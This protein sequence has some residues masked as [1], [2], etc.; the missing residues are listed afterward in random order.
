[1][2]AVPRT[3]FNALTGFIVAQTGWFIFFLICFALALPGMLLLPKI[4]PWNPVSEP[5]DE[6]H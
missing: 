2:A 5:K 6:S 1:L 3:F 4:A